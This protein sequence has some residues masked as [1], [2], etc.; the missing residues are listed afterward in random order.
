MLEA[1]GLTKYYGSRLAVHDVSFSVR[2]YEVTG[3]LGPNGSG[4]STTVKM[5]T[6]LLEPSAGKVYFEGRNMRDDLVAYKRCLGYVPEEAHVYFHLT[7]LEYLQSIGRLH[8]LPEPVVNRKANDL[9]RL[10]SLF[11][12]RYSP[13]ASYSKGI[14]QR[15]MISA[16]LHNPDVLIFDEPLS[17]V[18]VTTVLL[19]PS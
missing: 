6:G 12:N 11:P 14:K 7:G 9:L 8:S 13:I 1:R 3:Y 16:A 17:G 15:I 18:D 10:F 5:L 19:L 4:K 2:P